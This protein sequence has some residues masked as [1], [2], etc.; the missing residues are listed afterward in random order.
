[1]KDIINAIVGSMLPSINS[2]LQGGQTLPEK[3]IDLMAKFGAKDIKS[4]IFQDFMAVGLN[5]DV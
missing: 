2:G 3:V 5:F 4:Q 1:L